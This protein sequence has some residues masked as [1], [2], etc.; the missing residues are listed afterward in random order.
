MRF[1]MQISTDIYYPDLIPNLVG[2][3]SE[4]LVAA[5]PARAWHLVFAEFCAGHATLSVRQRD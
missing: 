4:S 3:T 1:P 5:S 2:G